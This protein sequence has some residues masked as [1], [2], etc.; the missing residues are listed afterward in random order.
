[1]VPFNLFAGEATLN[2]A[3]TWSNPTYGDAGNVNYVDVIVDT[4]GNIL[5]G[6]LTGDGANC[7]VKKRTR[8]IGGSFKN[9]ILKV[10]AEDGGCSPYSATI[11]F[12]GKKGTGKYETVVYGEGNISLTQK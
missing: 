11:K 7:A 1:M 9:G 6:Y 4:N 12:Q 3:G 5:S 2:F 10:E 8:I